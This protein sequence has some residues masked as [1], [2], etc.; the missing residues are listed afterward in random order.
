VAFDEKLA[1]RMR[2]IIGSEV[3]LT[4]KRMFGGLAFMINGNMA[5]SASG[6]GGLL[7]R[8]EPSETAELVTQAHVS[9]F[10]MGGR[11]MD[12]WI[13]VESAAVESDSELERWIGR[14]VSYARSLPAKR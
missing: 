1:D 7:V 13:H 3:G 5:I 11:E 4:E 10:A 12:G 8:V 6:Q 2:T 14:G 9:R